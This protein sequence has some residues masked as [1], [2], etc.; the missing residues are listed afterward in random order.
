MEVVVRMAVDLGIFAAAWILLA[1]AALAFSVDTKD[2]DD[3]VR[4]HD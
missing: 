3:W 4:H 1:L 2:G